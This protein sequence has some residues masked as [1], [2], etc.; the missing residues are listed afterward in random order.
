MLKYVERPDI[1]FNYPDCEASFVE[2][3]CENEKQNHVFGALY[4]HPKQ[5]AREFSSH[6][7]EFLENF[8]SRKTKLTI[9]GDII[10]I[11]LNKSNVVSNEYIN[12]INSAGF[13]TLIN[14]PTRIF[15]YEQSHSVSCSTLDHLITNNSSCFSKVGILVTDVS[16]HLPIFGYMS[17]NKPCSNPLKNVYRRHIHDKKKDQYLLSRKILITSTK[18]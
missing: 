4:R 3:L 12:V 5:Y 8:T 9:M 17:L 13:T 15:Y 2:V 16:D 7:G 1:K 11:D 10:N 14:Q 6:L 18:M